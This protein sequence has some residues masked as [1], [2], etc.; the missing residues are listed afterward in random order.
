MVKIMDY[1]NFFEKANVSKL[2]YGTLSL[3]D[4]QNN[5]TDYNKIK[6]LNYA[7]EKGINFLDTAEL[8]NNYKLLKEFIKDK[9]RETLT[10]ATK[11]Y[12]YDE[13]TAE[14]SIMKAL[15]EMTPGKKKNS[16][17][18]AEEHEKL[19]KELEQK[20]KALADMSVEFLILK[21]KTDGE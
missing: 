16:E 5:D 7:Y 18:P 2:C 19:K 1:I 14:Y 8:Y 4:L 17:V 11:S 6:L 9:D 10:L 15:K 12:A 13:K 21:K 3:S 20:E